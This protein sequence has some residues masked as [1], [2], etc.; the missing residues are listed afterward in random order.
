MFALLEAVMPAVATQS[1][2][3]DKHNQIRI[4]DA[5]FDA[6]FDRLSKTLVDP[7]SKDALRAFLA[8]RCTADPEYVEACKR[9]LC[10][11]P[12]GKNQQLGGILQA[13]GYVSPADTSH[14]SSMLPL[15]T[16]AWK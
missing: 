10:S 4:P 12:P 14:G 7:P 3:K 15:W 13:L 9:M 8:E 16:C 6:I 11:F 2:I 5:E 1:T